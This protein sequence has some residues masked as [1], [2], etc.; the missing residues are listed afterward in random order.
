MQ[1]PT[2]EHERYLAGFVGNC[3]LCEATT[4]HGWSDG[5]EIV[6]EYGSVQHDASR[7]VWM[8]D[9]PSDR[10]IGYICDSCGSRLRDEGRTE[11]YSCPWSPEKAR[12]SAA[13]IA[14]IERLRKKRGEDASSK[15]SSHRL[16]TEE[17]ARAIL[18]ALEEP[19]DGD[20][21]PDRDGHSS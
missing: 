7:F 18:A 1:E 16:P 5:D 4:D 21:E 9:R 15:R 2:D 8:D 19:L 6:F 12:P 14:V 20:E 3:A 13:A 17:E 10:P 11:L